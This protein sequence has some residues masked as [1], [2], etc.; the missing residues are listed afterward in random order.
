MPTNI[1]AA[2]RRTR[3]SVPEPAARPKVQSSTCG[4]CP[5][6]RRHARRCAALGG[7]HPPLS[8]TAQAGAPRLG[9]RSRRLRHRGGSARLGRRRGLGRGGVPRLLPRGRAGDSAV[10][11]SRLTAPGGAALGGTARTR[12]HGPR[13][14]SRACSTARDAGLR[15]G[16]SRRTGR[17]RVLARAGSRDRG[18]HARNPRRRRRRAGDA[19]DDGPWATRS[20]SPA[21]ESP[22]SAAASRGSEW[23][24]S[25]R[26][27]RLLPFCSMPG[28][29][30]LLVVAEPRWI[31][32]VARTPLA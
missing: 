19:F 4:S 16:R 21:W 9:R 14:R 7:A 15:D 30:F 2:C 13:D 8:R 28:S 24:R 1:A 20:S 26:S 12:L 22:R 5:R 29:C 31:L 23:A 25:R 18:Q 17:A 11:R 27:S 10:A 6:V 32:V 3:R